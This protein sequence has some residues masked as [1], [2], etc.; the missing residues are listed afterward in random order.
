M[1]D[2]IKLDETYSPA[3]VAPYPLTLTH[4]KGIYVYDNKGKQYL[5]MASGVSVVNFGHQHP[6]LIKALITQANKIAIVPRLF[7]NEPL[8]QLLESACKFTKM[9]QAIPMNSGAEATE[10]AI[11]AARKW[12]YIKKGIPEN[13]AEII[14]C[15]NNFHGRTVTTVSMSSTQKYKDHFGPLTPGFTRI[16]YNDVAA[17]ESAISRNTAAFIVEPIQGE[18]GV[19]LPDPGYLKACEALCNKNQVLLIIDEIQTGMGRTGKFLASQYDNIAPDGILL[20]K[21]L[22]GGLVPIS[23]FLGRYSLMDV[24]HPGEHGSTFG[25]NPLASYVA[26]EALSTLQDEKLAENAADVGTY[27]VEQLKKI[28]SPIITDVRGRG[29]LIAIDVNI[30]LVKSREIFE[31]FI[32]GGLLTIDTRNKSIRLLPPLIITKPQI[33]EAIETIQQ[34]FNEIQLARN[35]LHV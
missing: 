24:F 23:L 33:D 20:G 17:L 5:D 25:G 3:H 31:K 14:V 13:E 22:G 26:Y 28:K 10:T 9:E 18:A 29:L 7:H 15:N 21:S 19:I 2:S 8:S 32:Q 34:A 16:P 6:R 4:G 11:K 30:D 27:F 1:I 35:F 12:G